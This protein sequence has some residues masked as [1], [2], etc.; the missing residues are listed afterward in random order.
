MR[1]ATLLHNNLIRGLLKKHQGYEVM[2]Y[3]GEG[4]F[5]LV[6]PHA[7]D[8]I[9]WCMDV[10]TAYAPSRTRPKCTISPTQMRF[11]SSI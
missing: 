5:C 2:K 11:S 4:S 7:S 9:E 1:D 6:F 10:Q 8:A 3:A